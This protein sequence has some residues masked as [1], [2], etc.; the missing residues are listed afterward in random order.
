MR[1]ELSK[2]VEQFLI[3]NIDSVAEL[4]GLLL[5]RRES[6]AAYD[7]SALARRLYIDQN[8]AAEVLRALDKRGFIAIAPDAGVEYFTYKPRTEELRQQIDQLEEVYSK[9]LIPITNLLHTKR[10]NA[11][12]QFADAFR[13]REKNS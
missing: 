8:S 12:Q 6:P 10:S 5:M 1:S 7:A 11:V 3:K 9:F 4:E 2:E 13:L